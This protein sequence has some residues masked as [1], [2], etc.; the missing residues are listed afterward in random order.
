MNTPPYTMRLVQTGWECYET[1][2]QSIGTRVWDEFCRPF[3]VLIN[4]SSDRLP[5]ARIPSS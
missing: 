2:E 1:P 3:F 4:N 5:L